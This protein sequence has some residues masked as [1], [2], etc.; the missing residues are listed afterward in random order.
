MHAPIN[1]Y[2]VIFSKQVQI[3]HCINSLPTNGSI[4]TNPEVGGLANA[5]GLLFMVVCSILSMFIY[6]HY[7]LVITWIRRDQSHHKAAE[8]H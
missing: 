2:I 4:L 1:C 6:A 8:I 7:L 5:V 3:K